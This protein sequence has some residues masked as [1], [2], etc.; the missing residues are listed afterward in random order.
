MTHGPEQPAAPQDRPPSVAS[1]DRPAADRPAADRPAADRPAASPDRPAPDRPAADR[2][3]PPADQI[4]RIWVLAFATVL[5]PG[6]L[7]FIALRAAGA[8]LGP[9]GLLGLLVMLVSSV[10]Y[11]LLLKRLGWVGRR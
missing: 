3:P 4:G 6:I 7:V 9:A 8:P 2:P 5:I 11:P 10:T 1:R